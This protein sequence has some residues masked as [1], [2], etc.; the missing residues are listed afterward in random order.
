MIGNHILYLSYSL[1]LPYKTILL[2]VS[3]LCMWINLIL[4]TIYTFNG[5]TKLNLHKGI[6]KERRKVIIQ[7]FLR[8]IPLV[9][10]GI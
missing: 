3:L 10:K 4:L 6:S 9:D 2:E 7:D 8:L 5:R 1:P